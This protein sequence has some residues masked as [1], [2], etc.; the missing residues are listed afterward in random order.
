MSWRIPPSEGTGEGDGRAD[1]SNEGGRSR[2][3]VLKLE[4]GG[5]G[6][7]SET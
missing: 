2:T 6:V 3:G 1:T 7:T 5:D 4:G